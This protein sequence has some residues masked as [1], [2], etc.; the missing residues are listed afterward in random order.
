M[1]SGAVRDGRLQP[2]P[3]ARCT[4]TSPQRPERRQDDPAMVPVSCGSHDAWL[5]AT[6]APFADELALGKAVHCLL[7]SALRV[8]DQSQP[9]PS[10]LVACPAIS[11]TK[12]TGDSRGQHTSDSDTSLR[13]AAMLPEPCS[14][15]C[16]GYLTEVGRG[17]DAHARFELIRAK[18]SDRSAAKR[19]LWI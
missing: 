3:L 1:A 14:S 12:A 7:R 16:R 10:S 5:T 2:H 18:N 17:I 8:Q 11:S 15:G 19:G 6:P 4:R 13:T 9:P